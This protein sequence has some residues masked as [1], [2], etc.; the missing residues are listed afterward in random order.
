MPVLLLASA[1]QLYAAGLTTTP[2]QGRTQPESTT[3]HVGDSKYSRIRPMDRY[4]KQLVATG[5]RRS[6]MFADLVAE[7]ER[8]NVIAYIVLD[9]DLK[10]RGSTAFV[11]SSG[12]TSYVR[13]RLNSRLATE[14]AIGSLAHELQHVLEIACARPA[15]TSDR[16]VQNLYRT[17][18]FRVGVGEFES[19]AALT[20]ERQ[21]RHELVGRPDSR[22]SK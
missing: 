6:A 14:D 8:H 7:I 3:Q 9:P 16:E 20:T 5:L 1:L 22:T 15:V 12:P 11:V 21:V 13:V 10:W 2:G 4:S 17:I 19:T 18:G